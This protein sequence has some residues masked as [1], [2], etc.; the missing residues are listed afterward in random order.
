MGLAERGSAAAVRPRTKFLAKLLTLAL[1]LL[2]GCLLLEAGLRL[3]GIVYNGS[4]Y[5]GDLVRG[6]GLRPGAHAWYVGESKV[7][8]RVNRDGLRDR[9]HSIEKPPNTLRVA[10]LGDS[11]AEA[12]NVPMD[13]TFSAVMERQ[14]SACGRLGNRKIEVMNFGVSGYGTTQEFLT[15]QRVWKYRPDIILVAFYTGNDMFNNYRALNPV[16]ADQ[17]PYF[18]FHGQQLALDDSFRN[19]P[20]FSETYMRLFD[21]RGD[22]QNR[23]RLLQLLFESAK[24]FKTRATSNNVERSAAALGVQDLEDM[25]YSDPSDVR[26][27]EAWRVTEQILLL[28]RDEVRSHGAELFV[29][30]LAN[31]AQLIPDRDKAQAVRNR[32]GVDSLFY[33]DLRLR[34]FAEQNGMS[35]ITLAPAMA[36]YAEAHHAFLN[37]GH[38]VSLG[39]GHWNEDGHR[40]AGELMASELCA[41]SAKLS[42]SGGSLL[43]NQHVRN[44]RTD[45]R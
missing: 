24:D 21:L 41:R 3:V 2:M 1:G 32:L 35:V 6:W 33:P 8:I 10:V 38:N 9:E 30:T 15:L 27:R 14:M 34:T 40:L 44:L 5:T 25:I 36:E 43:S 26:M 31:R 11:Y 45:F 22:L 28:M 42:D 37:G 29:A 18:V 12:L 17:A 39:T 16:D 4:F 19:S 23:S 7:Y 13:K 20:K